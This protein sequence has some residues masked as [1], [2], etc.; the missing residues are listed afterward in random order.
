MA[1]AKT[2][3]NDVTINLAK[4]EE[5]MMDF[6]NN[7]EL[8]NSYEVEAILK[9]TDSFKVYDSVEELTEDILS[10]D[11]AATNTIDKEEITM[12]TLPIATTDTRII[13]CVQG[14]LIDSAK[15]GVSEQEVLRMV[16][17]ILIDAPKL[18]LDNNAIIK[19][20][21]ETFKNMI[22]KEEITMAQLTLTKEQVNEMGT[23]TMRRRIIDL[24]Y[25]TIEVKSTVEGKNT[26]EKYRNFLL[27]L[28]DEADVQR[29]AEQ[30]I[31][32][33]EIMHGEVQENTEVIAPATV[34]VPAAPVAQPAVVTN[35]EAKA[36]TDKLFALIK[37]KA[38]DNDK[39]GFG[40][41]ISSFMLQAVILEAGTG[42]K[43][44]K[45]HTVTAEEEKLT[46]NIYKW[47]KEKGFIKPV[48]YSVQE[49]DK[50]RIFMPEYPGKTENTTVK[51]IP[52]NKSN[53]YTAKKATS[54][55]VTIP[56]AGAGK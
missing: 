31:E 15:V 54:F 12:R 37:E 11:K 46:W 28:I 18:G 9:V 24:G 20:I 33:H 25:D 53:G 34:V 43:K 29:D 7:I 8:C 3:K 51:M 30:Q 16:Q 32:N 41:T 48:V 56:G 50:V 36:K 45:G 52:Y 27:S 4:K 35:N 13:H 2:N 5:S 21:E 1:M 55:L 44:L 49:D 14:I 17:G 38:A 26:T 40:Y 22:N 42:L 39:K 6:L 47:L 10:D 19:E 23:M